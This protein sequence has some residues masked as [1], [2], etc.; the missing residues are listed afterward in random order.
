L[1]VFFVA[2]MSAN[3]KI[4][5]SHTALVDWTSKADL[6]WFKDITTKTGVV[7]MGRKTFETLRFP[8]P[9]RLNVVMTHEP[10]L[11]HNKCSN[12]L[13]TDILPD[14]LIKM[15]EKKGYNNIAVVGGQSIFTLFLKEKLVDEMY[16]TYE[17]IIFDGIDPFLDL[18]E[19]VRMKTMNVKFLDSGAWVVHYKIIHWENENGKGI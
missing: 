3:G 7:V 4:S 10:H 6:K 12:V 9:D 13:F 8:L 17:P 19:E 2:V 5:R 11:Y 18:N 15:L 1:S 16:L 14:Q